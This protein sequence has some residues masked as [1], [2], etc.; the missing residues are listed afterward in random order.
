MTYTYKSIY[1]WTIMFLK[2]DYT[3]L[4]KK[5]RLYLKKTKHTDCFFYLFIRTLKIDYQ[6]H[7]NSVR[8]NFKECLFFLF[9]LLGKVSLKEIIFRQRRQLLASLPA[10]NSTRNTSSIRHV[11]KI[12]QTDTN[13]WFRYTSYAEAE[14]LLYFAKNAYPS[15]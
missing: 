4:P 11:W 6:L 10:I 1:K 3:F 13:R 2:L 8:H 5:Q 12:S 9:F 15:R 7:Y 14:M